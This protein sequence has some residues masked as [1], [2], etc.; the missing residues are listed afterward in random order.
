MKAFEP[1]KPFRCA[2]AYAHCISN[3][4]YILCYFLAGALP[5]CLLNSLTSYTILYISNEGISIIL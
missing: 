3:H 5:S 4:L 1:P 2:F